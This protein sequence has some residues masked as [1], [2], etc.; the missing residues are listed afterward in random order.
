M[1]KI[2][3][4]ACLAEP[5][6]VRNDSTEIKS[7]LNL[8]AMKAKIGALLREEQEKGQALAAADL[9]TDLGV[10]QALREQGYKEGLARAI[11]ILVE[12]F[13]E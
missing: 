8:R 2:F 11:D 6:L 5:E 3:E 10:K 12:T 7:L 13:D 4:Q 1:D 9:T